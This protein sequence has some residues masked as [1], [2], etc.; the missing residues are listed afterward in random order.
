MSLE[1]FQIVIVIETLNFGVFD[2]P[3]YPLGFAVGPR[4][5]LVSLC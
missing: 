1:D 2:R 5:S 4:V 3:L